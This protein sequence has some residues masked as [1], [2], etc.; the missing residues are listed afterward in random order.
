MD[1]MEQWKTKLLDGFEYG[2]SKVQ[3]AL[4]QAQQK[5]EETPEVQ[6]YAAIGVVILTILLSLLVRLFKRKKI[7]HSRTCWAIWE[8]ENCPFLP[9]TR[10]LFTSRNCHIHGTK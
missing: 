7:Q 5:I 2:K 8:W 4:I 6:L 3:D 9:A 10:W 1:D